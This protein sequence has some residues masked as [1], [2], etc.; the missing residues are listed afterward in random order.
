MWVR[1]GMRA[2]TDGAQTVVQHTC[3]LGREPRH[4]DATGGDDELDRRATR[5]HVGTVAGAP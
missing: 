5:D 1:L 3:A 2:N 4:P